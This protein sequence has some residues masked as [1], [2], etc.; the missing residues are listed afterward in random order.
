M[1]RSRAI[2]LRACRAKR[3]TGERGV[4]N[5]SRG[6]SRRTGEA[7][8]WVKMVK[9]EMVGTKTAAEALGALVAID[10]SNLNV[11]MNLVTFHMTGGTR[12][13]RASPE[14]YSAH[15]SVPVGYSTL[16]GSLEVDT[17]VPEK[18]WAVRGNE[19]YRHWAGR[20]VGIP[21]TV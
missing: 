15:C 8:K 7:R 21:S 3:E 16:P 19:G 13:A 11:W 5:V 2:G 10:W 14:D 6:R 12:A 4:Q 9:R 1:G 18:L 20:L 17:Q